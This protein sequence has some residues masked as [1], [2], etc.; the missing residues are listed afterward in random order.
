[1]K[2]L[3]KM[4]FSQKKPAKHGIYFVH[5]VDKTMHSPPRIM[6]GWDVAEVYFYAGSFFDIYEQR[7]DL[8]GW[9]IKTLNGFEYRWKRGIWLKGPI[10]PGDR[11]HETGIPKGG[12]KNEKPETSQ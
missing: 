7:E 6:A 12:I 1:M 8:S 4:G 5:P 10:S 11:N 2:G 9:K 3:K